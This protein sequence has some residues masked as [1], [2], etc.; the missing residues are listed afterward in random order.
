MATFTFYIRDDRYKVPT[1]ALVD[2]EGVERARE[3][4][5]QRLLESTSHA[6]IDVYEG[7]ELRFTVM[8]GRC[9]LAASGLAAR[10]HRHLARLLP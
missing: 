7:E 2:A 4:A 3:L 5:A 1:L 8:P 6:A 9:P 10:K